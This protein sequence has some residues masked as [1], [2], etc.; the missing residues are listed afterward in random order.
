MYGNWDD[1]VYWSNWFSSS[2]LQAVLASRSRVF[3][4]MLYA[5]P[6]PQRKRETSTK[7]NKLRLFLKRSSEP[8][9]NLQNAAQ[10]VRIRRCVLYSSIIDYPAGGLRTYICIYVCMWCV[11]VCVWVC[12]CRCDFAFCRVGLHH[13]GY[14]RNHLLSSLEFNSVWFDIIIFRMVFILF[15][16]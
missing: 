11:C 3:A 6:S 10:Q 9:L 2:D 15:Y 4:K 13:W 1:S 14:F 12:E 8:L 5:A 16:V 7:E